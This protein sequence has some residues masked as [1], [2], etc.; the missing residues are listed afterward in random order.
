MCDQT[1]M[2]HWADF[3]RSKSIFFAGFKY[4]EI[5]LILY[6]CHNISI[7][8]RHLKRILKVNN[9]G[10]RNVESTPFEDVKNIITNEI[11]LSGEC[12]GYRSMWRRLEN[13]YKIKVKRN[14]V[15]RIMK[16]VDPE[17]VLSRKAHRLKRRRY[18]VKGPNF[19][20]H[21][22]GYDKLKPFGFCIH[23]AIDGYSRRIMWLEVGA[24]NN[25]PKCIAYYYLNTIKKM[26]CAPRVIR[27]DCGTENS[28][29]SFLQLL[30]RYNHRD[31]LA[32][33]KSFMYG[34]STSNQ[35]IEAW[36]S[37][38]RRQGVHWWINKLNDL[39][40]RVFIIVLL[41]FRWAHYKAEAEQISN[42]YK[43]TVAPV[44]QQNQNKYLFTF[45]D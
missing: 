5:V 37:Y 42:E 9:F 34:K 11:Q 45:G 19:V 29:I 43:W 27:G 33:M 39:R 35:R 20:W 17:G 2:M 4:C 21:I 8:I 38:L 41:S 24:S 26:K 7:S 31:S 30:L 12:I 23:G 40:D 44:N 10:R 25:D 16:E 18:N 14:E 1:V 3:R 15:M 22:D 6:R 32:G 13:D 28:N 36:W